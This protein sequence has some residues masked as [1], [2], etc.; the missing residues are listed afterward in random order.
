MHGFLYSYMVLSKDYIISCYPISCIFEY[1]IE[2]NKTTPFINSLK[3][4]YCGCDSP[5]SEFYNSSIASNEYDKYI[6][7]QSI[8]IGL[9]NELPKEIISVLNCL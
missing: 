3:C 5:F 7:D 1:C 9:L 2:C 4:M 6:N 8:T